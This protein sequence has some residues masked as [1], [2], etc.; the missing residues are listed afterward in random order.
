MKTFTRFTL[1]ALLVL[2]AASASAR[3]CLSEYN[4]ALIQCETVYDGGF[5]RA[6]CKGDAFFG[7]YGCV[8]SEATS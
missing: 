1:A 5:T 4:H 8:G 3:D 7:Y 2:A 6:G